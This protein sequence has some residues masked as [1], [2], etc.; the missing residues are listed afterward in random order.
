MAA[1]Q[2]KLTPPTQLHQLPWPVKRAHKTRRRPSILRRRVAL[3]TPLAYLD[4]PT[5]VTAVA[6]AVPCGELGWPTNLNE[7]FELGSLIGAGSYGIVRLSM[8]RANGREVRTRPVRRPRYQGPQYSIV[9]MPGH[10][11][12]CTRCS[13]SSGSKHV[14]ALRGA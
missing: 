3:N 12:C 2:G 7:H 4:S 5:R 10:V 1:S 6:Q 14:G 8:E 9:V 11:D 13:L